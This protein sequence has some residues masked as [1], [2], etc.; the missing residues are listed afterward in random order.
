M[1]LRTGPA[2]GPGSGAGVRHPQRVPHPLRQRILI[3]GASAGLGQGMARRFAALGRDLAL[4]ARRSDR[5]EADL[6]MRAGEMTPAATAIGQGSAIARHDTRSR[7]GELAM[8][9]LVLHG[10]EDRLVP[11]EAGREL[12]RL[13]PH[14]TLR[15]VPNA[16]HL[17]GTDAEEET[18][19][20]LLGFMADSD[21]AA[22]SVAPAQSHDGRRAENVE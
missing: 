2:A 17:L 12:A 3:S 21:S 6:R 1:S 19:S 15:I 18:A 7:L 20:A 14:A 11:P 4:A 22:G 13:S 5:L 8:P 10:E 16:G 9:V